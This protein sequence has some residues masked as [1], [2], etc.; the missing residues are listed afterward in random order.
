MAI[1]SRALATLL[2]Q[3]HLMHLVMSSWAIRFSSHPVEDMHPL[4]CSPS[5][6]PSC[7]HAHLLHGFFP[8]FPA[9]TPYGYATVCASAMASVMSCSED[10]LAGMPFTLIILCFLPL[11]TET[12]RGLA[13]TRP[14]REYLNA[15]ENG[16][17]RW[18]S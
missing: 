7:R 15:V 10:A 16:E 11:S 5:P 18:I 6:I 2:W 17:V 12:L 9:P 13:F 4:P 3:Q 8:A 14:K 1:T